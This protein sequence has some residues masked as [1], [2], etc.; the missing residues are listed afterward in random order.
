MLPRR[1]RVVVVMWKVGV[2]VVGVV[3]GVLI[4]SGVQDVGRFSIAVGNAKNAT[5]RF[6]SRLAVVLL[7][8]LRL[9]HHRR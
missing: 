8:S 4:S 3:R 5:G 1:C 7:P 6:I 9:R 2:C